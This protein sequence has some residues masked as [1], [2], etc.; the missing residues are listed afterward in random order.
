[1]IYFYNIQLGFIVLNK[2][3]VTITKLPHLHMSNILF[4]QS[5]KILYN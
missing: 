4:Q 5:Y 3:G 1:M 2:Q